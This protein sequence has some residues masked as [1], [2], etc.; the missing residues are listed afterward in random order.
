M[1]KLEKQSIKYKA[2]YQEKQKEIDIVKADNA[3]LN[4]DLVL[5]KSKKQNVVESNIKI[6]INL[7]KNQDKIQRQK[8]FEMRKSNSG[9]EDTFKR[10][11]NESHGTMRSFRENDFSTMR[12]IIS[13]KSASRSK[14]EVYKTPLPMR[15]TRSKSTIRKV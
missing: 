5:N 13:R 1:K 2:L 9:I 11:K 6:G 15:V 8:S 14:L 12:S 10:A 7:K 4:A 3:R